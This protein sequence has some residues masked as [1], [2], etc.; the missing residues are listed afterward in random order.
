MTEWRAEGEPQPRPPAS[1]VGAYAAIARK[2]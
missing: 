1:E 2:R